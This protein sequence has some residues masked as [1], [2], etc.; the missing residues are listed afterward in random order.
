MSE[1]IHPVSILDPVARIFWKFSIWCVPLEVLSG[2]I[3]SEDAGK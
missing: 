1:I 2:I 3:Q